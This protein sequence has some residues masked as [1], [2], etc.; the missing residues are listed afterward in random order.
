VE[1]EHLCRRKEE[2]LP[3]NGG[4]QLLIL[5]GIDKLVGIEVGIF[6]RWPNY[7]F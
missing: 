2:S 1:T 3:F 7:A 6:L 4:V 5:N